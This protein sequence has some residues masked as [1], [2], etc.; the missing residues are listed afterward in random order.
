[1]G[2]PSYF[3]YIITEYRQIIKEKKNIL[4]NNN[5][6]IDSNSIIYDSVLQLKNDLN[7]KKETK[8]PSKKVFEQKINDLVYN[9]QSSNSDEQ[10]R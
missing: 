4:I 5:L 6:F 1:M 9:Q 10:F 3:K 7:I 8:I 2:I